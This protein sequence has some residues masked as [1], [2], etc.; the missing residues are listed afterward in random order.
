MIAHKTGELPWMDTG[1]LGSRGWES[2]LPLYE[3]S[4]PAQLCLASSWRLAKALS[5]STLNSIVSWDVP[6]NLIFPLQILWATIAR[7]GDP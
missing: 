6:I 4:L 1:S 7:S 2:E 5:S 3:R